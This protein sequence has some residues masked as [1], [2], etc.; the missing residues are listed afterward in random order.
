MYNTQEENR[1]EESSVLQLM[2]VW[3]LCGRNPYFS[4]T[5]RNNATINDVE[6]AIKDVDEKG[7]PHPI[8]Y[9]KRY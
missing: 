8:I 2:K 6:K 7:R 1:R 4:Q 5:R 9:M 3:F